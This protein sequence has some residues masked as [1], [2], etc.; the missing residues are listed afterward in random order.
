MCFEVIYMEENGIGER[1]RY[2]R[3]LAG[4]TQS[5]LAKKAGISM[6]SIRRYETGER[7]PNLETL[8]K[9]A[10]CLNTDIIS[11]YKPPITLLDAVSINRTGL[12]FAENVAKATVETVYKGKRGTLLS[13]FDCLNEAGQQKAVERVEELT[14]IPKY[15]KKPDEE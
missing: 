13:A 14:E 9:I 8:R 3:K 12:P 15:Q 10:S 7:V 1:I 4:L 2:Y 6:M 5:E 11:F